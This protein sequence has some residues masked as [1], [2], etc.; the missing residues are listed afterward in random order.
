MQ[1]EE[2]NRIIGEQEEQVGQL[3][4]SLQNADE[5]AEFYKAKY[6]EMQ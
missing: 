5:S 1:L 4:D 3:S 2:H 6:E